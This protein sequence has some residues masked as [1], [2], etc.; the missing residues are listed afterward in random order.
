MDKS[1]GL[2]IFFVLNLSNV[3]ISSQNISRYCRGLGEM[4]NNFR[5]PI[6]SVILTDKPVR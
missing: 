1:C 5:R 3:N 6:I 4:P 2:N